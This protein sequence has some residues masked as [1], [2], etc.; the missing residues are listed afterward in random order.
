[1]I[2]RASLATLALL[3]ASAAPPQPGRYLDRDQFP[4]GMAVLP[5]PPASG[6]PA[7]QLDRQIFRETRS[8]AG[9]PRWR[10][11]TDDVTNE[12]LDRYG[13]AMSLRVDART[14]PVTAR[15]LDRASAA[16]VVDP[17]KRTY[18]VRRPYLDEPDA[19]ICEAKTAHLAGNGDYPSGH[20]AAGWLEA[21]ILAELLPDRAGAI[22]ARGRAYGES[23]A[24]CGSHS[25][26]AVQA[27]YLAGATAYAALHAS[28]AFR[29]DMALA[30]A[31]LARLRRRAA[32][33]DPA[34]C[35]AQTSAL[36]ERPW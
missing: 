5:P 10:I 30:R 32:P 11:A 14:A 23:R 31:E 17:V 25:L 35:A 1:M 24:V 8:L 15:L 16:P 19:P 21:L 4:D 7:A 9:S 28:A 22:L 33:P 18:Q 29:R 12:P 20:T 6:S 3:T 2:R 13:C 36:A 34:I 27:G 26:S